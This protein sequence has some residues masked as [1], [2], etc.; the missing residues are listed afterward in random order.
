[1]ISFIK[2][3]LSKYHLLFMKMALNAPTIRYVEFNLSFIIDMET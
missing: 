2:C 3:V 1:M